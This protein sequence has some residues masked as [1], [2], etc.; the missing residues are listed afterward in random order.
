MLRENVGGVAAAVIE[1]PAPLV[2]PTAG[3]SAFFN[4][5]MSDVLILCSIV[6]TILNIWLAIKKLRSGSNE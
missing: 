3:I 6:Y 2:V 5:G 1:K 4:F